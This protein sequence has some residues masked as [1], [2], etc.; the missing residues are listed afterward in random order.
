[1]ASRL[2]ASAYVA[3]LLAL[4]VSAL[5]QA[6]GQA[7]ESRSQPG[8]AQ[9]LDA[10]VVTATRRSE[11]LQDV[12]L[13][14]T[15]LG[16]EQLDAKG[17]VGYEGLA[18]ETPGVVLNRPSA[19][20]NNFTARG[21]ATNGYNAN[22]QS[23]VAIYID[24]LPISANGNS[25][26][27]DPSLYD[28][29][30]IE[31]LRGPQGT[32]FGSGSLAGAL[33]ILT[34]APDPNAFDASFLAD[35]GV[36]GSSSLRQRYNAMVNIPLAQD[37]MALR[38]VG[39]SR[40]E[41]GYIDNLGTGVKD[42]NV[43]KA[44]GGRATLLWEPTDRFSA[45]VRLSR[46]E[47]TPEDSS[48]TNPDLGRDK[49]YSDRPD[50]F[51]GTMD[52]YNLTL[53]YQFDGAH[54]TSSSTWSDYDAAFNVD[55]A[56]T[57]GQ[58]FA[59]ALDAPFNSKTFVQE[60]RLVSDTGGRFEWVLGG[61][62][63]KRDRDVYFGYRSN[64]E[65]LQRSGITGLPDE[66]YLRFLSTDVSKEQALFGQLT[67]HFNDDFWATLG[68]R[69]GSTQAQAFT[70]AG[71]YNSDYLT[72]AY[73]YAFFGI[74]GGPVTITPVEAATGAK[75]KETGPSYR[76][77]ASWR[78]VPSVTTYAAVATGFR[79]PV[80]NARAGSV[81]TIDPDDLV[82]PYGAD[83]DKL[84]NYELG[85]KG[86]W[87]DG[88][89]AANLALY[90]VDWND[91]QVQAN[92]VSDQVQFATNIGGAYSRGLEFELMAMPNMDWTI[93]LNGSFNRA[94]VDELT[95]QEAAISGTVLGARLAAPE[96]SASLVTSYRF[97]FIRGSEGNASLAIVHVGDFPGQ[98]QY[99]PG[100]PGVV[101]P[102][103]DYT[104]AYTV[105]NANVAA[106]FDKYTVGLYVENLFD[107][108]SVTYVHP[109]AFL[110]GRYAL[111]RPRTVGVRVGYR[112]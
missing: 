28:V 38:V 53:D 66:Y 75:A 51:N 74:P 112:F 83:S 90:Y 68:L 69:Y 19:N 73:L 16:Q 30:R 100:Q 76:L 103:F 81:S 35:V 86:S 47:S 33:R 17:I 93:A 4:P 54:L 42:A 85:M 65:F 6:T 26:V 8:G 15:V 57:Y 62:H 105:V 9:E 34:H 67:Y 37:T 45:Q 29:E 27:L 44:W 56:G 10:I 7:L 31:F 50:M 59:F 78:P 87:L 55:L 64:E 95:P 12:P 108:R 39:F 101:S 99:V 60:V 109:E 111:V 72:Q 52:N 82:I 70:A 91:I 63:F 96:F 89:L 46:E 1:M 18:H 102:T 36:T 110:D 80:V 24:E 79:A 5:A 20:F 77:S 40:N 88:R 3:T 94:R 23:T 32:L 58:A 107:D 21:I 104:D 2:V 48:L 25:T 22:L 71:G 106:A 97:D 13:S 84:I 14:V 49:R 98:F 92:R 61:F 43:L 11:K 41:D